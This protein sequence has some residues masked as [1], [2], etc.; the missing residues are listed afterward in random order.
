MGWGG[1]GAAELGHCIDLP[2]PDRRAAFRDSKGGGQPRCWAIGIPAVVGPLT[3]RLASSA[4]HAA[5]PA[6]APQERGW[7]AIEIQAARDCW[8]R[9]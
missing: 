8:V 7:N 5:A 9:N 3:A 4:H 1:V 2:E 6:A